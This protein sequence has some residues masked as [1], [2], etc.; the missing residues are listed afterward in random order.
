MVCAG[1]RRAAELHRHRLESCV[2]QELSHCSAI[3]QYQPETPTPTT[4]TTTREGNETR[5]HKQTISCMASQVSLDSS[6]G[7]SAKLC[8]N[9]QPKRTIISASWFLRL[10]QTNTTTDR[11]MLAL[12]SG[13]LAHCSHSDARAGLVSRRRVQQ[14]AH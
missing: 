10:S 4:T 3:Y 5:K 8:S 11:V 6:P 9:C 2:E 1:R 7:C 13:W 12:R 14:A